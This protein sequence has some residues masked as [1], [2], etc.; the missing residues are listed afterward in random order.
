[1]RKKKQ[2]TTLVD[3]LLGKKGP[4]VLTRAE[5][6]Q[7]QAAFLDLGQDNLQLRRAMS[8]IAEALTRHNLQVTYTKNPDGSVS[9]DLENA[10]SPPVGDAHV[11]VN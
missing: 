3:K 5:L 11:T 4:V 10:P 1:M 7:L 9:F 2:T 6:Q 8:G